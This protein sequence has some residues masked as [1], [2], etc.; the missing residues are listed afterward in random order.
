VAALAL[1]AFVGFQLLRGSPA[2][3][4]VPVPNVVG[5]EENAARTALI[6]ADLKPDVQQIESSVEGSGRVV[7]TVP[8]SGTNVETRST[9]ILQIGAGPAQ[10]AV[11]PLVGKTVDEAEQLL[12]DRGLTLGDQSEE[13]TADRNLVGKITRSTPGAGENAPGGSAVAVVVGAEQPLATVPDV[14]DQ[15][16][17][18][19][20]A[21]LQAAG[22]RVERVGNGD[23]VSATNP[24][25]N[26]QAPRG[27]TVTIQLSDSEL[28]PV[29]RVIG[30]TE[31]DARDKLNEAGFRNVQVTQ[32]ITTDETEND[33][34][35]AQDPEPGQRADPAQPVRLLVGRFPG[36][37]DG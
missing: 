14:I 13:P 10:A 8:P 31:A 7:S 30:D 12:R 23:R 26:Q 35:L 21:A 6:D 16:A 33:E 3:A 32:R 34:V 2:R 1:L 29:P 18:D 5:Q 19:A 22:F 11:P 36:A 28:R 15:D 27:S 24:Q 9:V 37:D 4:E 25:A 17:D 20:E